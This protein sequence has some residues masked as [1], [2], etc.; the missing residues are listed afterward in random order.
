MAYEL[1]PFPLSLL[2]VLVVGVAYMA[3]LCK[4]R[5][6]GKIYSNLFKISAIV[7]TILLIVFFYV[8][9]ESML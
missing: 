7:G 9:M 1:I 5:K 8:I 2:F 6:T 3:V 4:L